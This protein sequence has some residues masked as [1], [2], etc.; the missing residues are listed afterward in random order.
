M[1]V[2]DYLLQKSYLFYLQGV[3]EFPNLRITKKIA[4]ANFDSDMDKRHYLIMKGFRVLCGNEELSFRNY[5]ERQIRNAKKL[6]VIPEVHIST[7]WYLGSDLFLYDLVIDVEKAPIKDN[8][9][10]LENVIKFLEMYGMKP[11]IKISSIV[12]DRDEL[13]AGFHVY[14]DSTS[15]IPNALNIGGLDIIVDKWGEFYELL[16]DRLERVANAEGL[17][18]K[19]FKSRDHMIRAFLSPKADKKDPKR[20]LGFSIP[21]D[22]R[23]LKRLVRS[24][25]YK[26]I[27]RYFRDVNYACS[28]R[29]IPRSGVINLKLFLS[30][31]EGLTS[32]K[33]DLPIMSKTTIVEDMHTDPLSTGLV[34][35]RR[36]GR[37]N[38]IEKVLERGLEDGRKRFILYC[39]ARYL[40]NVKGL[41]VREAINEIMYF[42]EKSEELPDFKGNGKVYESWVRSVI[43]GVKSKKLMPYSLE[44]LKEK[45]EELYK[46][47]QEVIREGR[48]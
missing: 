25:D 1:N 21:V 18:D 36:C 46:L 41:E 15:L 38:Y 30:L 4:I 19:T 47:V 28:F 24:G 34:R 12:L 42:I 22:L 27:V 9:E 33:L 2:Y 11:A 39:A 23:I 37:F 5:V 3:R 40:V 16:I 13:L 35:P 44:K 45:D 20:L 29:S 8:V 6:G 10:V 7:A 31:F 32:K 14:V 43:H 26:V 17:L 48:S